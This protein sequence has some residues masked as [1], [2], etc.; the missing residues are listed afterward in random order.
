[1]Q[2]MWF[3]VLYNVY[4]YNLILLY[5]HIEP[6]I[7]M[8]TTFLRISVTRI[9]VGGAN[10]PPREYPLLLIEPSLSNMVNQ[11]NQMARNSGTC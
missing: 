5:T 9:T 1:M 4:I 6:K 2:L 3:E 11:A 8:F 10:R 7:T